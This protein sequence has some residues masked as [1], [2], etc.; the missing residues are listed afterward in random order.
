MAP[1]KYRK[2][3]CS[4]RQASRARKRERARNRAKNERRKRAQEAAR[5]KKAQ[6]HNKKRAQSRSYGRQIARAPAGGGKRRDAG[7]ELDEKFMDWLNKLRSEC[8]ELPDSDE[9]KQSLYALVFS[10]LDSLPPKEQREFIDRLRLEFEWE[11]QGDED[12]DPGNSD[13]SSSTDEDSIDEDLR[14]GYAEWDGQPPYD[15]YESPWRTPQ[16]RRPRDGRDAMHDTRRSAQGYYAA[17]RN[18]AEDSAGAQEPMLP[19]S[20]MPVVVPK[21]QLSDRRPPAIDPEVLLGVEL[22]S[23][24]RKESDA[25]LDERVREEQGSREHAKAPRP[26]GAA[27]APSRF[28]SLKRTVGKA[29][30]ASSSRPP[31]CLLY[32]SDAADK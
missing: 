19:S 26:A 7:A 15:A 10:P 25:E 9:A 29:A 30:A 1:D 12:D 4:E 31:P 17:H 3:S 23:K 20:S 8:D 11:H 14:D 22:A 27:T 24:G 32:T 16:G 28:T 18:A 5:Q 6:R 2:S 21:G 13:D